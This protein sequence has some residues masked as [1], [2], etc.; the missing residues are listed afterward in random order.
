[1]LTLF[2]MLLTL[3]ILFAATA[4][5]GVLGMPVL[6]K[7]QVGQTVRDD[8]PKSH[9]KKSGTL[10][11][12][13]F[14]FLIPLTL[15]AIFVFIKWPELQ[16]FSVLVLMMLFFAFAGF[17]DDYIKVR[18][19]KKGLSVMQKTMLLGLF[20]VLFTLYYLYLAPA[21]PF[22]LL[23]LSSEPIMITGWFKLI[24]GVLVVLY[25]FFVCNSVN[26]TDGVDGLASAVTVVC[27]IF[28]AASA[29]LLRSLVPDSRAIWLFSL[30]ITG[31]CLGFL[32][33]NHH[34][35]KVFMGD[36][37]SQALGAGLAA[38]C[39]MLGV[40]W[41]IAIAGIIYMAESFS[42]MIQVAYFKKT[43]GKRIF[44]MSPIHHHYEYQ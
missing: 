39:L 12:G 18:V 9:Y 15:A 32:L 35:A 17:M 37:G 11:F 8:G 41:L 40:P 16:S 28:I 22:L 23:P 26:L 21:E 36:T 43:G 1:M 27:S 13:G 14:F 10:T 7:L 33:F 42:V 5:F 2:E 20:S 24:Y 4:L 3:F 6:R 34:P 25:L 38:A 19:S 31:G 44:R 29:W 30:A